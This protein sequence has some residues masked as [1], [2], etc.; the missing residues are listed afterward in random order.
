MTPQ[1]RQEPRQERAEPVAVSLNTGMIGQRE[2]VPE[3]ST[4]MKALEYSPERWAA[5]THYLKD[6]NVPMGRVEMWRGSI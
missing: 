2:R 1:Q 3:V 5:P 6:G 4:I